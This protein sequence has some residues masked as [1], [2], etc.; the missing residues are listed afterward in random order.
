MKILFLLESYEEIL[1]YVINVFW[2]KSNLPFPYNLINIH[3]MRID[4][5]F[6][7]VI[8]CYFHDFGIEVVF[9]YLNQNKILMHDCL[10]IYIYKAKYNFEKIDEFLYGECL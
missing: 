8:F 7:E 2:I 10:L 5:N 3:L 9:F 6:L 4:W 1:N